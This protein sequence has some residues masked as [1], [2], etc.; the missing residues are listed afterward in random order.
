MAVL[1]SFRGRKALF[2]HGEWR[3]SHRV[4]ELRLARELEAWIGETGGP[5]IGSPDP[6][7]EAARAVAARAGG[8][9]LLRV[10]AN[11]RREARLYLNR[12]QLSFDF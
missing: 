7:L 1:L 11:A 8:R 10:P 12:R 4:L 6:E 2:R 9:I 5:R 3:A